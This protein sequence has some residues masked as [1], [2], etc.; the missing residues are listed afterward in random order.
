MTGLQASFSAALEHSAGCE[1]SSVPQRW[2]AIAQSNQMET[3]G[4]T[5]TVVAYADALDLSDTQYKDWTELPPPSIYYP[6]PEETTTMSGDSYGAS[7]YC[8][9]DS[10]AFV[11][12]ALPMCGSP[13]TT[14]PGGALFF[15][16]ALYEFTGYPFLSFPVSYSSL[17]ASKQV[18]DFIKLGPP[19][20]LHYAGCVPR[21]SPDS[22]S[23][24]QLR[25]SVDPNT[26]K[27]VAALLGEIKRLSG[28]FVQL[29]LAG[30]IDTRVG[31]ICP[32]EFPFP[33]DDNQVCYT[34]ESFAEAKT[35]PPLS[36][37]VIPGT[38]IS[39]DPVWIGEMIA[40]EGE[41]CPMGGR[42]TR[43]RDAHK[44]A[45]NQLPPCPQEFPFPSHDG[46]A[47]YKDAGEALAGAGPPGS[48]CVFE[49]TDT[50]K[51]PGFEPFLR[52]DRDAFC[53]SR[54]GPSIAA[55]DIVPTV[56]CA[57]PVPRSSAVPR[58]GTCSSAY[59]AISDLKSFVNSVN[60]FATT[61]AEMHGDVQITT[62]MCNREAV[63][64]RSLRHNLPV[65]FTNPDDGLYYT[66]VYHS[67]RT[68]P[69]LLGQRYQCSRSVDCSYVATADVIRQ[70]D[71]QV[72]PGTTL[73]SPS[74][75]Y[76]GFCSLVGG[77][78]RFS[79]VPMYNQLVP[80]AAVTPSLANTLPA[81]G[82]PCMNRLDCEAD[83]NGQRPNSDK[84]LDN[85]GCST[86]AEHRCTKCMCPPLNPRE[87]CRERC[88]QLGKG[89]G[90]AIATGAGGV[91]PGESVSSSSSSCFEVAWNRNQSDSFNV[92]PGEQC[93]R[94]VLDRGQM[95]YWIQV[96]GSF[97]SDVWQPGQVCCAV[98]KG[99]CYWFPAH[100]EEGI[101]RARAACEAQLRLPCPLNMKNTWPTFAYVDGTC[102]NFSLFST[103]GACDSALRDWQTST[104]SGKGSALAKTARDSPVADFYGSNPR[105]SRIIQPMNFAWIR[106]DSTGKGVETCPG[107]PGATIL[108]QCTDAPPKDTL[109]VD[110]KDTCTPL[111]LHAEAPWVRESQDPV[112]RDAYASEPVFGEVLNPG[113]TSTPLS[114]RVLSE[115]ACVPTEKSLSCAH[116]TASA[117]G[118]ACSPCNPDYSGIACAECSSASS[119]K[120]C[121]T[122]NEGS[123]RVVKDGAC[124]YVNDCPLDGCGPGGRCVSG[125]CQCSSGHYLSSLG[126]CRIACASNAD[127]RA[128]GACDAST[129]VCSCT[130]GYA[131]DEANG[132]CVPTCGINGI[133]SGGGECTQLTPTDYACSC[134]PG[135]VARLGACLLD[136]CS[137]LL[138]AAGEVTEREAPLSPYTILLPDTTL[139]FT[140]FI[141][142]PI[143]CGQGLLGTWYSKDFTDSDNLVTARVRLRMGCSGEYSLSAKGSAL[144]ALAD[145][146]TGH[147]TVTTAVGDG[148]CEDLPSYCN[149]SS[150]VPP[151]GVVPITSSG[152]TGQWFSAGDSLVVLISFQGDLDSR[153]ME[154]LNDVQLSVIRTD[155]AT[156]QPEPL[157]ARCGSPCTTSDDC[158]ASPCHT[159]AENKCTA[160]LCPPLL[161]G[162]PCHERC[163][164]VGQDAAQY[165]I[166]LGDT[167]GGCYEGVNLEGS[168]G[169]PSTFDTQSQCLDTLE[170]LHF[171]VDRYRRSRSLLKFMTTDYNSVSGTAPCVSRAVAT[172]APRC[173]CSQTGRNCSLEQYCS[174][175]GHSSGCTWGGCNKPVCTCNLGYKS[176]SDADAACLSEPHLGLTIR[177]PLVRD[178]QGTGSLYFLTLAGRRLVTPENSKCFG[179]DITEYYTAVDIT[180][181][182]ISHIQVLPDFRCDALT[183]LVGTSFY[184]RGVLHALAPSGWNPSEDVETVSIAPGDT[185]GVPVGGLATNDMWRGP[186]VSALGT[187][188]AVYPGRRFVIAQERQNLGTVAPGDC[189]ERCKEQAFCNIV[190]YRTDENPTTCYQGRVPTW[191]ELPSEGLAW[192][193]AI[194]GEHWWTDWRTIWYVNDTLC[195][196]WDLF[197]DGFGSQPGT[198][199]RFVIGDFELI[200][201][202]NP[203][204]CDM[205]QPTSPCH[206]VEGCDLCDGTP[207][208][209]EIAQAVHEQT[210]GEFSIQD[211]ATEILSGGFV[212]RRRFYARRYDITG[213][214][215]KCFA[216]SC[217]GD[218]V[219]GS[220]AAYMLM[221]QPALVTPKQHPGARLSEIILSGLDRQ[222]TWIETVTIGIAFCGAFDTADVFGKDIAVNSDPNG[223]VRI[224]MEDVAMGST[225]SVIIIPKK[226]HGTGA[227]FFQLA[228]KM[229]YSD[230][231][232]PCSIEGECD[233]PG[234]SLMCGCKPGLQ[235]SFGSCISSVG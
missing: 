158:G 112:V 235:Y 62:G 232:P 5:T 189:I 68:L 209:T 48:W 118:A 160:C 138:D 173:M 3:I 36:W 82:T 131:L 167:G 73:Y 174:G 114:A 197:G 226:V 194:C 113:V 172:T 52:D 97:F 177:N 213:I 33:A 58:A 100:T 41:L 46:T 83:G 59:W 14:D 207:S 28:N 162:E 211:P 86:C 60:R 196:H 40:G 93:K 228:L 219:P 130:G 8:Y 225:C 146:P 136:P 132:V 187:Y 88:V 208:K 186:I 183:I 19:R 190:V 153:D 128:G 161:P 105:Q 47:C 103:R 67:S 221:G 134:P 106:L 69:A 42:Y 227:I 155:G 57:D 98:S 51:L 203:L 188:C 193:T 50:A 84:T 87:P 230:I 85:Y 70:W 191:T 127:C 216:T 23:F 56:P 79:P 181:D 95:S 71:P 122:C 116:G 110:D 109:V 13:G 205:L 223:M 12:G 142:G 119:G 171:S 66:T 9:L 107:Y 137:G 61:S 148:D 63:P 26:V 198:T 121:E 180:A 53:S 108:P 80:A 166:S 91:I 151:S 76:G 123:V 30:G 29:E 78:G 81:C 210:F 164:R 184:T 159:C 89:V 101:P 21:V 92:N 43:L 64:I 15:R 120:A 220:N 150:V 11:I 77:T 124:T 129:G 20:A 94:C 6:N 204:A 18:V 233:A 178:A 224:G 154:R 54:G 202:S 200:P 139:S 234:A 201:A 195:P 149:Q 74:M 17:L 32:P 170:D 35:G 212:S 55:G 169:A 24:A 163:I 75:C 182:A 217:H 222:G 192:E 10:G 31:A 156:C 157:E 2:M 7:T 147:F 135:R 39:T 16:W 45:T 38:A 27:G 65:S 175:Q 111:N 125:K 214:Q 229:I 117:D 90:Y 140:G 44:L 145:N 231:Q 126:A 22:S 218:P 49:G 104:V 115:K 168:D 143:D 199:R 99:N 152:G 96:G 206:Q 133:C 1:G 165:A 102:E 179:K 25:T 141:W 72:P 4:A 176:S 34:Q 37:C 144:S 185:S 215:Y